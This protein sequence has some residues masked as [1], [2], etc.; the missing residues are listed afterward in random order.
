MTDAHKQPA[1][2]GGDLVQQPLPSDT[3]SNEA[4][5][6]L[7]QPGITAFVNNRD[8]TVHVTVRYAY[9]GES[10]NTLLSGEKWLLRCRIDPPDDIWCWHNRGYCNPN[11]SSTAVGGKT[12]QIDP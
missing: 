7:D 12:Y 2:E 1:G 11:G 10:T 4:V 3:P 5:E 8:E 9:G 6:K